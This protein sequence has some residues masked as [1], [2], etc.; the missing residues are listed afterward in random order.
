MYEVLRIIFSYEFAI[1]LFVGGIIV[2]WIFVEKFTL[3]AEREQGFI[4]GWVTRH[5]GEGLPQCY[6]NSVS[7][8]YHDIIFTISQKERELL[9]DPEERRWRRLPPLDQ[10]EADGQ[11]KYEGNVR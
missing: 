9:K 10:N 6:A 11:S 7:V 8:I 4:D 2:R 1:G 5:K 3:P